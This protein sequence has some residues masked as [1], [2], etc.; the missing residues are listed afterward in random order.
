MDEKVIPGV[1]KILYATDLSRNSAYA[2]SYAVDFAKRFDAKIV[3]VHTIEPLPAAI[4]IHGSLKEEQEYYRT[5]KETTALEINA[6]IER[7]CQKADTYLGGGCLNLVSTILL[8]IGHPVEEILKVV[9]E[10]GC[11]LIILGT[12]GKGLLKQTFLGSVSKAV[13]ERTRKPVLAVPLSIEEV[14][15]YDM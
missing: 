8:P 6:R 4:G 9:D 3:I 14:D 11:D 2:F 5:I 13:I 15:W 7:F 12:H 10:E 1:K